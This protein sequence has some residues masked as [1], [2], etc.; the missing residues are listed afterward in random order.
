MRDLFSNI[1]FYILLF[2]SVIAGLLILFCMTFYTSSNLQLIRMNQ[3]SAFISLI[4]LYLALLPSPLYSAFPLLPFKTQY[5]KARRAI[6]VSA[7]F[8]A[9]LHSLIGFFGQLQ[10]FEGL[11]FLSDRYLFSLFL[12]FVSLQ[13][14]FFLTL[15]SFDKAVSY[16]TFPTW[17]KLHRFIYLASLFILI[18]TLML[19]THFTDLSKIIPQLFF[20]F[21]SLLLILEAVRLDKFLQKKYF[22][23]H[24]PL[25]LTGILSGFLIFFFLSSLF[26]EQLQKIGLHSFHQQLAKDAQQ[27]LQISQNPSLTGD[28]SK[29]Y[30]VGLTT[31]DI[32]VP[33]TKIPLVFTIYDAANGTP[34]LLYQ[35]AYEKLMHL[36][37]VDESLTYFEHIHPE[38]NKNTF[39]ID[40]T[41]PRNGRY[42]LYTDFQPLGAIEQ[43]MGFTVNVGD[44]EKTVSTFP[45][46]LSDTVDGYTITL[47]KDTFT[48]QELSLGN[49]K[50]TFTI[51]DSQGNDVKTLKPYLASFGH[52]VMINTKSYDYVHVH[53]FSLI[54]PQKESTSG[55]I[56]EFLPMGIY[57]PIKKGTYK[58]FAQFNPNGTLI[59]ADFTIT[60]K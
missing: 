54:Q 25:L 42:H 14:L 32:I 8:F 26:S 58:L 10:G 33:Q 18:H 11:G 13:I 49:K 48:S 31:P 5:T 22:K 53:P 30:T 27:T 29:R 6:G 56:V 38:Q 20:F 2:S 52:L 9:L 37:I 59:T 1:R 46:K 23:T 51:K 4:F 19:G 45:E 60:V 40:A 34:Q 28:R 44:E 43:Q 12:G 47:N 55:P 3:M 50:M 16:L 36:I 41:F 35:R 17:K 57:G 24:T 7:F 39:S 15:T 21:F